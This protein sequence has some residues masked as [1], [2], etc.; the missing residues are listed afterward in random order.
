MN[1]SR[2]K[3]CKART[4]RNKMRGTHRTGEGGKSLLLYDT[5]DLSHDYSS[6]REKKGKGEDKI[7]GMEAKNNNEGKT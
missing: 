4:A 6:R 1:P 5:A 3:K 2:G 7:N